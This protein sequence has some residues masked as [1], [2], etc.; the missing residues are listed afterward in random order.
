[1]AVEFRMM[2]NDIWNST[3]T[4]TASSEDPSFPDDNLK[5]FLRARVWKSNPSG[6]TF[7]IDSTNEDLDVTDDGGTFLAT[8]TS[9]TFTATTL[10][11]EIKTQLDA[12]GT[13]T[14]TV[15]YSATTGLWTIASDGSVLSLLSLS[16]GSAGTSVWSAI[17]FDTASDHTG[18][19]TYTGS[20]IAIH[21]EERLVIDYKTTEAV[22]SFALP[23]N[24][25][26]GIEFTSSA[27]VRLQANAT[28]EWSSPSVDELLTIDE[29]NQLAV[30]FFTSDQSFR[31]WS[32]EI[33]DPA[34]PNLQVSVSKMVISKATT[35]K[36]PK[37]GFPYP[38]TDLSKTT[39]T[40]FGHR[41]YDTIDI[42]MRGFDF[43]FEL[44]SETQL[45]TFILLY[46]AVGNTVPIFL[47]IDPIEEILDNKRFSI[48]GNFKGKITANNIV[49]DI[50]NSG[51]SIEEQM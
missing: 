27:T 13:D 38:L 17:G 2:Q 25:L 1:M 19:T 8:L 29:V 51:F 40:P 31:F 22:D 24:P 44:L 9:G 50:F 5:E 7:I 3:I 37:I 20:T 6:G 48:Y 32:L 18:A 28:N 43:D 45:E 30:H 39:A 23:F 46:E 42:I 47:C 35:V 16:G 34:N 36:A 10:A 21:T 33:I 12:S 4:V 11:T 15:S 41:Y 26:D 49:R 14:F